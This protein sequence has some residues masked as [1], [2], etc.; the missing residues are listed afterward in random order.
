MLLLASIKDYNA[1]KVVQYFEVVKEK[2]PELVI[3]FDDLLVDRPG[4][5]R[6][7]RV[8]A[9][10]PRLAGRRRGELPGRRPGRRG[11]PPARQDAR[12]DRL[13]ARP[14]A[15]VPRHGLDRERLLRPLAGPRPPRRPGDHRPGA[16]PR[17]GRRRGH[18]VDAALAVD[19]ADPGVP[20]PLAQ[21]PAGRRGEPGPG[22][23]LPRAGGL[24]RR[25]SSSRPGYAEA[26]P[27][28]HVPRQLP[29]QRG[30]RRVPP[31]PLRPRRRGRR[32]DRRGD[33]QGRRRGRR[34]RARTS[35][36]RSTSSARSTTPAASPARRVDYYRQ[37]ADRFT[38]AADAVTSYT[39]KDLKLPEVTV[40][41][42]ADRPKVAAVGAAAEPRSCGPSARAAAA[43]EKPGA[44]VARRADARVPQHRRGRREGL[45]GRPDAA[46]PDP[47]QPR[48]D[49]RDRPGRDHPAGRDDGQ[50][51]QRRR[52]RRQA[53]QGRP[54]PQE[55]RGLPRD[56]PRREPLRL[57]DRAG[58]PAGA[59]GPRGARRAGSG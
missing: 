58:H 54:R 27:Q 38:D 57:G 7:Q 44:E 33:L 15:R 9:R 31:R 28:E 18:P 45:P 55:G 19:P 17:A 3:T 49:R 35:G 5:P 32:G 8:R 21:E 50:A 14:L 47:P 43:A 41:R 36:R 26:L 13:P 25:S 10:L 20:R 40:V 51:R 2:A 29:V 34:S 24:T 37:V 56:G 42:P 1:R 12:R 59:G 22:R 16:P 11:P 30:A 48:R 4:L 23:R 52:L 53:P 46:L 39:R 6:H